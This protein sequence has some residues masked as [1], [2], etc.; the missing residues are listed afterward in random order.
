MEHWTELYLPYFAEIHGKV[1]ICFKAVAMTRKYLLVCKKYPHRKSYFVHNTGLGIPTYVNIL[2]SS[3]FSLNLIG[4][5]ANILLGL[6]VGGN[7]LFRAFVF[8]SDTTKTR[9][10]T[11]GKRVRRTGKYLNPYPANV[12]NREFLITPADGRWDLTW[13]LKG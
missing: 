8:A 5:N 13:C 3:N 6:R 12:E 7:C 1:I 9:T 4:L 2:K 11:S 10:V